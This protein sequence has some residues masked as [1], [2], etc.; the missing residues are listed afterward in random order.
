MLGEIGRSLRSYSSYK[1]SP[2]KD[3]PDNW[4]NMV[5]PGLENI[6]AT[7]LKRRVNFDP[8][9]LRKIIERLSRV[10]AI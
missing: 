8:E 1:W 2:I 10:W 5:D 9:Q 7:W 4:E 6:A 3:L